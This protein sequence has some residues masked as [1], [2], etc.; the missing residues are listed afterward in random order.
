MNFITN[1]DVEQILKKIKYLKK[2]KSK[3]K[4]N[5]KK[6]KSRNTFIKLDNLNLN[7]ANGRLTFLGDALSQVD[8]LIV[9]EIVC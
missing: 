5:F 3:N 2:F 4:I 1:I 6:K 8:Q 7:F 9:A